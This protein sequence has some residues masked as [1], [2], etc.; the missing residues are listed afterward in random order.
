MVMLHTPRFLRAS[1][2]LSLVLASCTLGSCDQSGAPSGPSATLPSSITPGLTDWSGQ[3]VFIQQAIA[4]QGRHEASLLAI[5]GV[6]GDGIGLA[7]TNSGAAV[8]LVFTNRA[9]V[10]GIPASFEGIPTQITMVG[11]VTAHGFTGTYRSPLPCGVTIGDNNQCAAGSIGALVSSTKTSSGASTY[12]GSITV[13][14]NQYAWGSSTPKYMLSCNHVL[15]DA[16][17]ATGIR[18]S[19]ISRAASMWVAARPAQWV[20]C[21]LG[22]ISI[23]GAAPPTTTMW[24]LRSAIQVWPA[25]GLR[26]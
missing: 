12:S 14:K 3:P 17:A 4:V 16:N 26:R 25:D 20:N 8:I 11:T 15:A 6:I 10:S 7:A 18:T 19:K 5:P 1:L 2:F 9:E 13:Y 21:T 22:V 24:R 23:T